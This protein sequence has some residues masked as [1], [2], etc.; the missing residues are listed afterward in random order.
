MGL[1]YEE[2]EMSFLE[3]FVFRLWHFE[4]SW[5]YYV[6]MAVWFPLYCLWHLINYVYYTHIKK[7]NEKNNVR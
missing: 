4:L 6:F 1:Y 7:D 5:F 3:E 2:C